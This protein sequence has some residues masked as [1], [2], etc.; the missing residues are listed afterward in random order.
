MLTGTVLYGKRYSSVEYL[1]AFLIAGKICGCSTR[2]ATAPV[3]DATRPSG[4]VSVFAL[5]KDHG[6]VKSKLA[7]PNA[8]LGYALV[9][10]N[11]G[12]DGYTNA[13]QDQAFSQQSLADDK[14][15]LRA[16]GD[17]ATI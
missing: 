17:C 15:Q 10:F 11:L 14:I 5:T 13:L 9:F 6:S 3:S 2:E 12:A 7:A 1:C 16:R 4:G 8:V